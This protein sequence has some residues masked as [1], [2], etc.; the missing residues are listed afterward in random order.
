MSRGKIN[1]AW[2]ES[3]AGVSGGGQSLGGG[4]EGGAEQGV[5]Y[6]LSAWWK[7]LLKAILTKKICCFIIHML[8]K[9]V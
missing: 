4:A 3:M 8:I 5:E 6:C 2:A 9:A 7:K 1:C